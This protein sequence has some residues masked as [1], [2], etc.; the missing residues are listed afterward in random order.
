MKA[1]KII[2][3]KLSSILTE[4]A[5]EQILFEIQPSDKSSNG[6]YFTNVALRLSSKLKQKPLD[7]AYRIKK[8]R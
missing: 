8:V 2:A 5:G 4:I 1:E 3:E 7:I 6:E